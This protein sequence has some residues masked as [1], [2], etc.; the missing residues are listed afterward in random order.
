M[1]DENSKEEPTMKIKAASINNRVGSGLSISVISR[2]RRKNAII[3]RTQ[4]RSNTYP[5]HLSGTMKSVFL[6]NYTP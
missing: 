6:K 4:S 5:F 2:E 3:K 1:D